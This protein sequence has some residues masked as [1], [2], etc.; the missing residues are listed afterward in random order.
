M[1]QVTAHGSVAVTCVTVIHALERR[2]PVLVGLFGPGCALS[3]PMP[4]WSR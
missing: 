2:S 1:T 3:A 4:Q